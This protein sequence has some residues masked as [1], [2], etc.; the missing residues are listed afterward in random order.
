MSKGHPVLLLPVGPRCISAKPTPKTATDS[1]N[2]ATSPLSSTSQTPT[3]PPHQVP[4]A[5]SLTGKVVPMWNYTSIRKI[6][7]YCQLG[8]SAAE[9][10]AFLQRAQGNFQMSLDK[11]R[12]NREGIVEGPGLKG[13][14]R[15]LG[16][17]WRGWRCS[18]GLLR[19]CASGGAGFN[20]G[21]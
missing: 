8:P 21:V 15:I 18:E 7:V 13:W 17:G 5:K 6:K 16:V 12:R 3:R 11:S 9:T 20:H 10:S 19:S 2:P 14:G 1:S 4:S